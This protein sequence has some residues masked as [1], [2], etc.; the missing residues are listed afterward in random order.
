MLAPALGSIG[1]A[2]GLAGLLYEAEA[3]RQGREVCLGP[4]CFRPAFLA[5]AALGLVATG[6]AGQLYRRN[7]A[8]Y[9]AEAAELHAYDEETQRRAAN[10]GSSGSGGGQQAD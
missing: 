6:A 5:L 9:A 8:L 1:L 3:R 7:L 4:A 2:A 10:G